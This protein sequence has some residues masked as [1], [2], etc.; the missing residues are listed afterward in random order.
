MEEAIQEAVRQIPSLATLV[1]LVLYFLRH[2]D[3][4]NESH[5]KSIELLVAESNAARIAFSAELKG[6]REMRERHKDE[7]FEA[8]TAQ[9][10]ACGRMTHDR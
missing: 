1:L 2:V 4:S 3:A 6:E 5:R 10:A 9:R 8:L 7:F